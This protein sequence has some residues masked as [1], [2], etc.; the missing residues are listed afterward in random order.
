MSD[1]IKLVPQLQEEI[2]ALIT[3]WADRGISPS[4]SAQ[5]LSGFSHML[6]A[7]LGYSLGEVTRVL[8]KSWEN[9]NGK[10]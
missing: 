6:L 8:A 10:L 7:K 2:V 4:E 5:V 9:H 3:A 1:N